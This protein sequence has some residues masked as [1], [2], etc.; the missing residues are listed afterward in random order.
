MTQ[1]G[2]QLENKI[3]KCDGKTTN[4]VVAKKR[5]NPNYLAVVFMSATPICSKE[6]PHYRIEQSVR[7][8]LER[9]QVQ[10]ALGKLSRSCHSTSNNQ[11]LFT[12]LEIP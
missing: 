11:P 7:N 5:V 12:S 10:R 6:G 1:A 8:P 2:T 3:R 9:D 4:Q